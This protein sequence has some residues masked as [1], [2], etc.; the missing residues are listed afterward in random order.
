M[1]TVLAVSM[2]EGDRIH[3][4][5]QALE[6]MPEPPEPGLAFGGRVE[7]NLAEGRP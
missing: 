2:T 6:E 7:Y 5:F 1:R 3:G 4:H